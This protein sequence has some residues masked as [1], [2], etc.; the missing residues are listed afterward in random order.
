LTPKPIVF[1][2]LA[3][4]ATICRAGLP[5]NVSAGWQTYRSPDYGF[6]IDYPK[7]MSFYSGHPDLKETQLSFIP[8]CD[9]TTVA[10][11]EYNGS[12]Y[13]GTNFGAAGLS[14][15]VLRD[16]R[17]EQDCDKIDTGSY[18]IKTETVNGIKFHYGNTGEAATS[19]AKSGPAY[20]AFHKNVCFEIAVAIAETSIGAFDP[21]A[22]KTFDSAKLNRLLDK[23][24]HT[25]KFA[26]TIKDGPGW[27]VYNDNMCGGVYEYPEG[28]TVRTTVEYSQARFSSNDITCSRSFTHHGLDYTVAAKANLKDKS[29]FESWLKSSGYPDL[30]KAR[31]V[32]MSKYCAEYN[33]EPYYYIFC[34]GVVYILSVSDTKH[35]VIIPH[36]DQVFT[37]LLDSFKVN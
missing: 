19:H 4:L 37:H 9:D 6:T 29:Q 10:C 15:N 24:V 7:N 35:S 21:G 33:A 31:V 2:C 8:I 16:L 20:R 1:A 23:M 32:V 25:F 12:E 27:K 14:V 3:L 28:E 17:T 26:A 22:I 36:D 18:P 13:E 5:T 34:Q 30:S 11:F